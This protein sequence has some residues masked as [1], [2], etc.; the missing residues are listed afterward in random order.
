[1]STPMVGNESAADR[2][3]RSLDNRRD[4]TPKPTPAQ[5]AMVMR[6]L[7]DHTAIMQMVRYDRMGKE[8]QGEKSNEETKWWPTETS[9]GRWFHGVADQLEDK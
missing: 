4:G 8:Q 9:I 3:L 5:V 1:M 6:A 7:A 2:L